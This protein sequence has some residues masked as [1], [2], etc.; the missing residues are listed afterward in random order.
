MKLSNELNIKDVIY[1]PQFEVNLISISKLCREQDC[2][3]VF[4]TNK[5]VIQENK[6]LIRIGSARELDGLYYS[7]AS[8]RDSNI[9][10][11]SRIFS[12]KKIDDVAPAILWHLRLG[13]LSYDK[14]KCMRKLYSY[15]PNSIHKACDVCQ[16]ARKKGLP[17]SISNNN[18]HNLFDLIH[19]EI[20]GP[21]NIV[22]VHGF[23]YFFNY[24]R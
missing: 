19:I 16:Q 14:M 13:H 24:F 12:N 21:F 23:K 8:Q 5:C 20:W 4:K 22:Y 17:F 10:F 18:A 1:L 15:V 6:N 9:C 11:V 3:Q 2:K 7:K